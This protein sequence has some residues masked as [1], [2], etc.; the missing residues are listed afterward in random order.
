[1]INNCVHTCKVS[2]GSGLVR[3]HTVFLVRPQ[4]SA[5]T[6]HT[7]DRKTQWSAAAPSMTMHKT[8]SNDSCMHVIIMHEMIMY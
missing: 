2:N 4:R 1:M 8:S 3:Q 6:M 5:C 7:A